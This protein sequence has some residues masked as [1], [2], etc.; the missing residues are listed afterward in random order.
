MQ[1]RSA[2]GACAQSAPDLTPDRAEPAGAAPARLGPEATAAG[3]SASPEAVQRLESALQNLKAQAARPLLDLSL[4]AIRQD[5]WRTAADRAIEAL[6]IDERNGFGWWLLAIAREKAGDVRSAVSCYESALQLLPDHGEIANDLG[7]LAFQLGEKAVAAQLFAHFL[8]RHPDHPE[9]V[10]NLACALRD[11]ERTDDAIDLLRGALERQPGE[12]LLWNTLGT[13]LNGRGDIEKAILFYD[14][15]LRLQPNFAKARYNRGSARLATGDAAGALADTDAALA[16]NPPAADTAMMRLARSS[17]LLALSD[18]ERGWDEYEARLDPAYAEV[19]HFLIDRPAWTPDSDV[20]GRTVLVIG[21]QGLG[22]EILFANVL[23]DL[24]EAIGPDGRLVLAV[25]TRQVP[26]FQR[27]FPKAEVGAHATWTVDG[28][29]LRGLPFLEDPSRI[30]VW[31]PMASLLRRWRR[32]VDAYPSRRAYMRADE[33]RTAVWRERLAAL[34]P[35]PKVGVLWKSLKLDAARRKWFSAFDQ[36]RPVLETPGVDFVNLQY[37]DCE[38][39][40]AQAQAAGLSIWNPPGIDLKLEL[41]EVAALCSALDLVIGPANATTNIAAACG[42]PVWL[43][44]TPAAW[45]RLGTDRY[46]WYPSVRAFIPDGLNA[47]E[48]VM[49]EVAAELRRAF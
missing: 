9:G 20:R 31:A 24:I 46:P 13:V 8:A 1:S 25:E 2:A 47:W 45:P 36:W 3:D 44:S 49:A 38:A 16:Q 43:I 10:N 23:P 41:D 6:R 12:A 27:A 42:A 37:G 29:M 40:L 33:Q 26:L 18:L 21:E 11:L 32:S 22:D 4:E 15:A 34:S 14:E 48:P 5:D 7:R 39:E 30:D 19:T 17:V 35:R 28:R